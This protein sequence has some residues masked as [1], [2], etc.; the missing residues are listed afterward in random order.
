MDVQPILVVEDETLIRLDIIEVLEAGGYTVVDQSDGNAGLA[1]ID[2]R[3][4]LCGLITDVNL[5]SDKSGWEVARHARSKFPGIA[6]V[7]ISGDSV[8]SW[9]AEG[10]PQ[11]L[12]LQK[13]FADAQIL[14]AI[15]TLLNQ[16]GG[17]SG[18]T[19]TNERAVDRK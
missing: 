9:P 15:T 14:G 7:Y 12:I 19:D 18:Q 1:E 5:G 8:A 4:E 11:S 13:P 3:D 2:R 6:V 10:V 16:S 17:Q